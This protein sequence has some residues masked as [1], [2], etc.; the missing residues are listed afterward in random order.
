MTRAAHIWENCPGSTYSGSCTCT[1]KYDVAS[2]MVHERGHAVGLAHSR[3]THS[4]GHG[5]AASTNAMRLATLLQ[6]SAVYPL[7]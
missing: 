7:M 2:T 1:K 6:R 4:T 5:A 3:Q